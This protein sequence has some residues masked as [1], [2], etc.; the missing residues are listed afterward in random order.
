LANSFAGMIG[1]VLYPIFQPVGFNLAM[2]IALVPG[3][4]A[5]EVA[6]GGLATIYAVQGGEEN[7]EGLTQLLQSDWTLPMALAFLAWY[8][9]APQC[10]AT[11]ATVRRETN[12]WK[13]TGFMFVYLMSLAWLASFATFWTATA[14]GL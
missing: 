10:L 11:L 6:V 8:V 1:S 3:L 12:S 5:R 14:L 7:V 13:W 4:A 2:V 9:Y